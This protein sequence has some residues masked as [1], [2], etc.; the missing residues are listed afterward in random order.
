MGGWG[1]VARQASRA[2]WLSFTGIFL[3][4]IGGFLY[5]SFF[6]VMNLIIVPWLA[7]GAPK[8]DVVAEGDGGLGSPALFL[9]YR[10]AI[11][12]LALGNNLLAN[13]IR[14]AGIFS[15]WSGV[16]M[17]MSGML[18]IFS[19][20]ILGVSIPNSLVFAGIVR[21]VAFAFSFLG[22]GWIG[23]TLWTAKGEPLQQ[24]ALTS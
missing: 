11:I 19:V 23:Y 12:T 7:Q 6:F 21:L 17:G 8:L 18:F 1:I 9:F 22:F 14:R 24:T 10:F 20:I 4:F 15:R 5:T 13:S 3:T 2:G 16:V